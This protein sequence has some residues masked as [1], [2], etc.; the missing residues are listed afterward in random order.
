MI[1]RFRVQISSVAKR[2]RE[3]KFSI[4][5]VMR[6]EVMGLIYMKAKM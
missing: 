2:A 1:L 5:H 3:L 4:R 6:V